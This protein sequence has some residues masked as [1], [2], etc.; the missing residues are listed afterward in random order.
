MKQITRMLNIKTK[1]IRGFK[2]KMSST[3]SDK[4]GPLSFNVEQSDL[5]LS[6]LQK[7]FTQSR[8]SEI[9]DLQAKVAGLVFRALESLLQER[10]SYN[11]LLQV[12]DHPEIKGDQPQAMGKGANR[13]IEATKPKDAAK[14]KE[15]Q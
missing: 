1:L 2:A 7:F 6:E 13:L 3:E 8:V 10:N 9:N 14:P 5:V 15:T 12:D 11:N 4:N